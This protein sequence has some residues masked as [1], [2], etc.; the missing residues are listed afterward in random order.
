MTISLI[1]LGIQYRNAEC[2]IFIAQLS[3]VMLNVVT[4]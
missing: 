2:R 3:V 1:T 4:L